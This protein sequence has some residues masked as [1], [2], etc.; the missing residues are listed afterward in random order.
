MTSDRRAVSTDESLRRAFGSPSGPI[1]SPAVNNKSSVRF[2][3]LLASIPV[4]FIAG[5]LAHSQSVFVVIFGIGVVCSFALRV[6][7]R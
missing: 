6:F 5:Y 4:A 7:W 1:N 2:V 3:V